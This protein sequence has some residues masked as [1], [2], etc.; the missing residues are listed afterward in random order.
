MRF[1][2]GLIWQLLRFSQCKSLGNKYFLYTQCWTAWCCGAS[3]I[4]NHQLQRLLHNIHQGKEGTS[5]PENVWLIDNLNKDDRGRDYQKP[6][7]HSMPYFWCD[8]FSPVSRR[9]VRNTRGKPLMCTNQ[10]NITSKSRWAA[11][12][13]GRVLKEVTLVPWTQEGKVWGSKKHS[14]GRAC[15]VRVRPVREPFLAPASRVT[16]LDN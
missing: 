5:A 7:F 12:P 15:G 6:S 16:R 4:D 9:F 2:W 8:L 1:I 14:S 11:D 13:K 10:R 3:A